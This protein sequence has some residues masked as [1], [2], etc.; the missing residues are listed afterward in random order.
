MFYFL[1]FHQLCTVP[2]RGASVAQ[3]LASWAHAFYHPS[4]GPYSICDR[5]TPRLC[6][7][8]TWV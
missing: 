7:L 8:S 4:S 2:E 1:R 5:Q 3:S 6:D